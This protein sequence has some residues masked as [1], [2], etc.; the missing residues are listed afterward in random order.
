MK[1]NQLYEIIGRY[2]AGEISPKEQDILDQWLAESEKNVRELE[3]HQK[4]WQQTHID[5]QAEDSEFVFKNILSKIDDQHEKE[6]IER[7]KPATIGKRKFIITF[8]KIAASLL[9]IISVWFGYK[10]INRES[11][12]PVFQV[13]M[14][15]KQNLAGQKSRVYLPDGSVVWLNSESKLTFPEKFTDE[16]REVH[17]SGEAFFD[18]LR[19][20]E[21][22]FIV[23]S[24]NI[25]TTVLGTAF[26]IRTFEDE[27]NI[28]VALE[29][30][31][32]KVEIEGNADPSE[33]YL[34]PGEAAK[35]S[36]NEGVIS[37]E[38]FDQ[39]QILS[40]KDGVIVFK[41]A[42]T[43]EVF[44]TLARW[45]GVEFKIQ[46]NA[47]KEEWTYTGT[48]DDETLENVLR[49]ISYTKEFK[50]SINQKTVTIQF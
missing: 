30:G 41:D 32:L 25:S 34:E 45:Y 23:R 22:P 24:G 28:S 1:L 3:L 5:F 21:Q 17:L 31:R 38:I 48:F 37:K 47:G 42:G 13:N 10:Y 26:N 12:P 16:K 27:G 14:V 36:K 50:Y 19:N 18:V 15:E 2:L 35:Y 49:S 11:E 43:G 9:I 44:H 4:V 8:S 33:I 29:N 7:Q 6:F 40:W 46:N 20:P 39:E